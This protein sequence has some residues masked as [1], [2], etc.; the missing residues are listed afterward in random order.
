MKSQVELITPETAKQILDRTKIKNRS[1]NWNTVR[2]YAEQMRAGKWHLNGET[3]KID[4]NGNA[5]DGNHRLNAVILSGVS[6]EMLVVRDVEDLD[7]FKT[8]D[9][10][11]PRTSAQIFNMDGVKNYTVLTSAITKFVSLKKDGEKIRENEKTGKE[12]DLINKELP[13]IKL[14]PEEALNIYYKDQDLWDEIAKRATACYVSTHLVSKS[15]VGGY[16]S[17]L[18]IEKKHDKEKVFEF[19]DDV[20]KRD[21]PINATNAKLRKRLIN[22]S[23]SAKMRSLPRQQLFVK[24]WNAY[25]IGKTIKCL[26]WR[27]TINEKRK[28]FN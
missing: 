24:A 22:V 1:L 11:R 15:E 13:L 10:G 5:F 4:I 8:V 14:S 17:Y 18:I 16:M 3:I 21:Q 23:K 25:L 12:E 6:V 20:L 28:D 2:H 7:S 26:Q 9:I 19:F 27:G